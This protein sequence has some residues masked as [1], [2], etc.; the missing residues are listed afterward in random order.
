MPFVQPTARTSQQGLATPHVSSALNFVCE[1]G[2]VN[3][4]ASLTVALVS[5]S[6]APCADR[7]VCSQ[8]GQVAAHWGQLRD[9][10]G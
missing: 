2:K 4:M 1:L 3:F 10:S 9:N 7:K 5:V 8:G 6:R